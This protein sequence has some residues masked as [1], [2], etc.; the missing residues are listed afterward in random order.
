MPTRDT[1]FCTDH[2]VVMFLMPAL[3]HTL[4]YWGCLCIRSHPWHLWPP[5][6]GPVWQCRMYM[7][8]QIE[9][10][11]C[12]A[13]LA[14]TAFPSAG[15]WADILLYLHWSSVEPFCAGQCA[16]SLLKPCSSCSPASTSVA[17]QVLAF[18]T[19][20]GCLFLLHGGTPSIW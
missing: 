1:L 16:A 10:H 12:S 20:G 2:G 7:Q 19:C 17:Q 11:S 13:A 6:C 3:L 14:C 18:C 15:R 9:H 4:N 5:C 8:H